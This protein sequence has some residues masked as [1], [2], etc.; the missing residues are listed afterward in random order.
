MELKQRRVEMQK[1]I[2][3]VFENE[4]D[5]QPR[6]IEAQIVQNLKPAIDAIHSSRG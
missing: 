4:G 6:L 2:Q 3:G 5:H 1:D